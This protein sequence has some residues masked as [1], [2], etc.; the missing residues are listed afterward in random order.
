[1]LDFFAMLKKIVNV[2]ST[3]IQERYETNVSIH[4]SHEIKTSMMSSS[5]IFSKTRSVLTGSSGLSFWVVRKEIE[6]SSKSGA[7]ITEWFLLYEL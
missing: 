3:Q 5:D 1:M 2:N 4:T 6:N 7:V